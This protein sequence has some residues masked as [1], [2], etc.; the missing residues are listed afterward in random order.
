MSA[1]TM[2]PYRPS[3][4]PLSIR[5][6]S[7]QQQRR[8]SLSETDEDIP[9]LQSPS[10]SS[11]SEDEPIRPPQ[12]RP[13]ARQRTVPLRRPL[14]N[15]HDSDDSD[16]DITE[17][18]A[19]PPPFDSRVWYLTLLTLSLLVP[20]Q[21]SNSRGDCYGNSKNTG[22]HIHLHLLPLFQATSPPLNPRVC[23][24]PYSSPVPAKTKTIGTVAGVG[25]GIKGQTRY[26][27]NKRDTR[28]YSSSFPSSATEC[29]TRMG[30]ENQIT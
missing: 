7:A 26:R 22:T 30:S 16:I 18:G 14:A 12:P 25:A 2:P 10:D 23:W 1:T 27:P 29:E 8:R 19:V 4:T 11:E 15:F 5:G 21:T 24:K 13:T 3:T 6:M 20:F 9:A 28:S 17:S